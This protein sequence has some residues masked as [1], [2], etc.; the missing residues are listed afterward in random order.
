MLDDDAAAEPHVRRAIEL[1]RRI[2]GAEV[3]PV[4]A[5]LE[6]KLHLYRG[7]EPQVRVILE[8]IRAREAEAHAR[9]EANA[10]LVPAEEVAW[11]MLDLATQD[12]DDS[13]WDD[14]E[15]RAQRYSQAYEQIEVVETRGMWTARQG[16]TI[17]ARHHLERAQEMASRVPNP[18]GARLARRLRESRSTPQ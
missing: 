1:D 16:R 18:L 10:L 17:E 7:E 15:E 13:A 4:T 9:G 14:L 8:R 5:L 11:S 6:A 2:S 12:A 3:R